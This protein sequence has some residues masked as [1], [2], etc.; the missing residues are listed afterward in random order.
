V[1]ADQRH[2][3]DIEKSLDDFFPDFFHGALHLAG[4]G[5]GRYIRPYSFVGWTRH[6]VHSPLKGA[7][8][9]SAAGEKSNRFRM[10]NL[11]ELE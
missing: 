7:A 4:T 1:D 11:R 9:L 8:G 6:M 2:D 10:L 5:L 3:K